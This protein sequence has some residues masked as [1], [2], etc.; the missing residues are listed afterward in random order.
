VGCFQVC[1]Q[2]KAQIN[3]AD[4]LQIWKLRHGATDN[5]AGKLSLCI[6]MPV[7]IRNNDATELCITKGQEAFVVGWQAVKGP[8]GKHVLDTLF[9]KLDKSAKTINIP[10]LPKNVVPLVKTSRTIECTLLSDRKEYIQRQQVNVLSNF[11]MTDYASQGKTRP[12]NVV[13]S[14]SCYSHMSYYTCLSRS[15]SADGTIIMQGFDPELLQ[16]GVLGILDKSSESMNC[17]MKFL[18]LDMKVLY[19]IIFKELLK[20]P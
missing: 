15:S 10:G 3:S 12:H 18:D 19:L 20:I 8:H 13:H 5:F 17:W 6:G 16:Q 11:A 4:Q 1:I 9:V 2:I 14:N 7:M